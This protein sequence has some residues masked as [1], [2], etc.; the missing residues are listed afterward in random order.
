MKQSL[1]LYL[2][3][4]KKLD[5]KYVF[6]GVNNL[7]IIQLSFFGSRTISFEINDPENGSSH[8]C[9]RHSF[10]LVDH[11]ADEIFFRGGK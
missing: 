9:T 1:K 4:Y 6:F 2:L 7:K 5:I 8:T 10:P 11:I 3:V